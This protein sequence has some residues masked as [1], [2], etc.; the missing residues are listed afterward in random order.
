MNKQHNMIKRLFTIF[1]VVIINSSINAQKVPG[2]ERK[3][4][5]TITKLFDGIA[6]LDFPKIRQSCT[7]DLLLLETGKIWTVDSLVKVLS[8]LRNASYKRDNIIN[9]IKTDIKGSTAWTTYNNT[10]NINMNGKQRSV[11]W[12]ESAVLIKKG[13]EWQ[14]ALLHSTKL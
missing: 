12:L 3:V 14:V 2:E 4:Q 1:L 10:A 5:E 6:E 9:F 13:R 8:L 7:Q 11:T